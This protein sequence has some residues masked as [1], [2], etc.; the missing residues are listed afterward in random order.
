MSE[1]LKHATPQVL[2]A[3]AAEQRRERRL[4]RR[5]TSLSVLTPILL[6]LLWEL[7]ARWGWID[8]RIFTS[9]TM[10]LQTGWNM[11]CSGQCKPPR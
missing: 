3:V 9:P 8:S 6:L 10:I 2:S 5:D 11:V 4:R 7:A 1:A